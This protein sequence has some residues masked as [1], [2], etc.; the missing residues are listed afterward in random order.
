[1]LIILKIL[2]LLLKLSFIIFELIEKS[3]SL[4]LNLKKRKYK[5][6]EHINLQIDKLLYYHLNYIKVYI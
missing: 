6:L 3:F 2:F 1:M 5:G 4:L